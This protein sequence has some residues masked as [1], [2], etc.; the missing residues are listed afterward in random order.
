MPR[1]RPTNLT[2]PAT[3]A[4]AMLVWFALPIGARPARAAGCHLPDRPVLGLDRAERP[5]RRTPA[6][7]LLERGELAPP[8]LTRVPCSGES[9]NT[10][11]TAR[12]PIVAELPATVLEGPVSASGRIQPFD[13]TDNRDPHPLRLDRP[14]R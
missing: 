14:P 5:D 8:I 9:P 11:V 6:W 3:L 12:V 2:R 4:L 10:T 13:D 7:A 1:P